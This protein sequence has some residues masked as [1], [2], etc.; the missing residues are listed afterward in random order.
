M[1]LLKEQLLSNSPSDKKSMTSFSWKSYLVNYST[2][3][4]MKAR[5]G[6]SCY[7]SAL[8]ELIIQIFTVFLFLMEN[9]FSIDNFIKYLF[10][11]F[12]HN[13]PV[14]RF[15]RYVALYISGSYRGLDGGYFQYPGQLRGVL[16]L[17]L[18]FHPTE[19]CYNQ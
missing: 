18:R 15:Y 16:F 6:T 3:V 8:T 9:S 10:I 12:E 7:V 14:F 17:K 11:Y 13:S 2:C 4:L 19:S 1:S 5:K